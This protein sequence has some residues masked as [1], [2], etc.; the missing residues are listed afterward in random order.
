MLKYMARHYR[1]QAASGAFGGL[2]KRVRSQHGITVSTQCKANASAPIV[3]CGE[4]L[5]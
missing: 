2:W 3:F 4:A 1:I 5:H